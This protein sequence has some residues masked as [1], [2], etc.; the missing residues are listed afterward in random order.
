MHPRSPA[1][2]HERGRVP[3]DIDRRDIADCAAPCFAKARQFPNNQVHVDAGVVLVAR[4][5]AYAVNRVLVHQGD[6]EVVRVDLAE[7]RADH[8]LWPH[9]VHHV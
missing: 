3:A 9:V 5:D 1:H 8:G 6:T 4:V 7:D 2:F